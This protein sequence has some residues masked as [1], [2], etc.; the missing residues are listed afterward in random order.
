MRESGEWDLKMRMPFGVFALRCD[1]VA[2]LE[3][4]YLP[5]RAATLAPQ[6]PLAAEAAKQ[7]R[8][9]WKNPRD[10]VFDLPLLSAPTAHQ[11]RTREAMLKIPGG[12]VRTYGEIARQIRSSPRAVGGACRANALSLIVPCHRVV[13]ADGPGGFMGVKNGTKIKNLLLQHEAK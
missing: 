3:T 9:Y 4:A 6:N 7:A 12:T 8:A 1:E 13:A 10:F 5:A 11:R 2:V